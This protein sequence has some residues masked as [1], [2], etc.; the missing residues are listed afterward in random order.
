MDVLKKLLPLLLVIFFTP[1]AFSSTEYTEYTV[2]KRDTLTKIAERWGKSWQEI[3]RDNKNIVR[4]PNLIYP[5]QR[6]RIARETATE[7]VH[8][9]EELPV[10]RESATARPV[11]D[12]TEKEKIAS[13]GHKPKASRTDSTR[14]R[15]VASDT[16]TNTTRKPDTSSHLIP[17]HLKNPAMIKHLPVGPPATLIG[18]NASAHVPPE[19]NQSGL[20]VPAGPPPQRSTAVRIEESEKF[21]QTKATLE[22]VVGPPYDV[23]PLVYLILNEYAYVKMRDKPPWDM[24]SKET[25]V[26]SNPDFIRLPLLDVIFSFVNQSHENPITT[27]E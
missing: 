5:G 3:W 8:Q 15:F 9:L 23:R 19:G 6:L 20:V 14:R 1:V 12:N 4:D 24:L 27:E 16:K 17:S 7:T 10:A 25:S 26:H 11:T 18:E 22:E 13:R 2:E 21:I